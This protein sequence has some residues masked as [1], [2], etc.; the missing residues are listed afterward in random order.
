MSIW[1][2]RIIIFILILG[3][4]KAKSETFDTF[5]LE[6]Q[7]DPQLSILDVLQ[8]DKDFVLASSHFID[9]QPQQKLWLKISPTF[10]E[11][12]DKLIRHETLNIF[13]PKNILNV[14]G[15]V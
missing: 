4:S 10:F 5:Y 1:V 2:F 13:L 12:I 3:A 11:Q 14:F 15:V 7:S 8:L 9:I 6:A